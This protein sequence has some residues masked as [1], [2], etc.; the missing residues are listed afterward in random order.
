MGIQRDFSH[1][2]L[3]NK[4]LRWA[5]Q[6]E[7]V[8]RRY[9]AHN[10]GVLFNCNRFQVARSLRFLFLPPQSKEE[11][12]DESTSGEGE[13][14]LHFLMEGGRFCLLNLRSPNSPMPP[15]LFCLHSEFGLSLSVWEEEFRWI[16]GVIHFN[17]DFSNSNFSCACISCS[18]PLMLLVRSESRNLFQFCCSLHRRAWWV[19]V[20]TYHPTVVSSYSEWIY[21]GRVTWL[22]L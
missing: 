20:P 22:G 15:L 3:W 8:S 12:T 10:S 16:F 14:N 13:G 5:C 1:F 18:H 11:A 7:E 19:G 17:K 9:L 21:R 4:V 2:P 6:P